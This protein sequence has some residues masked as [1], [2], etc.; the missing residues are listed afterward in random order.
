MNTIDVGEVIDE[1]RISWLQYLVMAFCFII[2][3]VDG[4]DTQAIGYVAP[5]LIR[6]LGIAPASLGSLFTAGLLGMAAGSLGFGLLADRTGRRFALLAS[7]VVFG[8][9]TLCK[10]LASTYG[11]LIGL[12][13]CAGLGLGGAYPNAVALMNEYAPHRLRNTLVTI[14]ACGYLFGSSVGGF[15]ATALIPLHGWQSVFVV[16]GTLPLVISLL[17]LAWMPDSIRQMVLQRRAPERVR[18]IMAVI[19]PDLPETAQ[20]TAA[21]DRPRGFP[22]AE[23]FREGRARMTI[24]VWT[25]MFLNLALAFFV[26]SWLPTLFNRAGVSMQQSLLAATSLPL[27]AMLGSLIWGRMID[28]FPPTWAMALASLIYA[29]F[30][31]PVGGHT[32][33]FGLIVVLLFTAG[34]GSGVQTAFNSYTGTIYPTLIRSTG[35]GWGIGIG[36]IGSIL[37]PL[38]GA[39]TLSWQWQLTSIFQVAAIPAVISA[40]C[41]I[42]LGFVLPRSSALASSR[43]PEPVL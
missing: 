1:R 2:L 17:M 24:L 41:L 29:I 34:I 9:F 22:V 8:L 28:K 15:V 36:R 38:F 18:R 19:A 13:F 3:L 7:L 39:A 11:M 26:F 32:D 35:L 23:L 30:L 4:F 20:F 6:T 43:R 10:A 31:A 42:G 5:A 33:N 37:G 21:E 16:G 25:V 14:A 27:G 12:Q 40:A